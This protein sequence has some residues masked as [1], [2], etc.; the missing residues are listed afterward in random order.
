[1]SGRFIVLEG[2]DGSGKSTIINMLNDKLRIKGISTYL[3]KEPTDGPFGCLIHQFMTGRL[4]TD[5]RAIA[6]MCVAD[7]IDHLTNALN[8][9][10]KIVDDGITVLSDRYYFSSYAYQGVYMDMDWLIEANKICAK[11]LR[12]ELTV[13]IDTAPETCVE[14]IAKNRYAKEKY[15]ELENLKL[16]RENYL[17]AFEKQKDVENV[18]IINGNDYMENILDRIMFGLNISDNNVI[19]C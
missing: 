3:T 15:E 2:I 7:R 5:D 6:A 4:N 19:S 16:V 10:K 17:K 18:L 8:G 11:I 12:A 14:R 9:I 13:F 1:M